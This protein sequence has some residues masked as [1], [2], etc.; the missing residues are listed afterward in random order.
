MVG[1][2][3]VRRLGRPMDRRVVGGVVLP[4]APQNP[5]PAGSYTT[6]GSVGVLSPVQRRE[7]GGPGRFVD[8]LERVGPPVERVPQARVA[9]PSQPYAGHL[10]G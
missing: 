2:W 10:A 5:S 3:G 8:A 4:A 6:Q 7:L 1:L 9:G